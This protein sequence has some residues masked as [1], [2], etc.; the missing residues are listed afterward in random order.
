MWFPPLIIPP[1]LAKANL[2]STNF[3]SDETFK[4]LI[5]K[6]EEQI[7]TVDNMD[8]DNATNGAI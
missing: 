1:A 4:I 6:K 2:D 5:N 3:E 8:F 7:E